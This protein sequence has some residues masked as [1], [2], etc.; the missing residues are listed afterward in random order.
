[1]GPDRLAECTLLAPFRLEHEHGTL[2]DLSLLN[3]AVDVMDEGR[4]LRDDLAA[5]KIDMREAMVQGEELKAELAEELL[6]VLG[7]ESYEALGVT[8]YG[9]RGWEAAP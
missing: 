9:E 5:G 7:E 8:F 2:D 3:Y 4:V 1:M 6:E